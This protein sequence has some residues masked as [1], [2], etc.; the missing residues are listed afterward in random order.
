MHLQDTP[1]QEN[2]IDCG[3]FVSQVHRWVILADIYIVTACT[4]PF[5]TQYI[6]Y[7]TFEQPMNFQQVGQAYDE[8][9]YVH[10]HSAPSTETYGHIQEDHA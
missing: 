1:Q 5:T 10:L 8:M 7:R 2:G 4:L 9:Q 3:V 6:L